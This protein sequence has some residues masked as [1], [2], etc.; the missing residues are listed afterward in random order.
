MP[1]LFFSW[2]VVL[3]ESFALMKAISKLPWPWLSSK[4]QVNPGYPSIT[5]FCSPKQEP[6]AFLS[7]CPGLESI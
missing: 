6:G 5:C 2:R 4:S 3:P 7:L 1:C